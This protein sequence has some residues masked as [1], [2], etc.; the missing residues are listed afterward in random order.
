MPTKTKSKV[1]AKIKVAN[2]KPRPN[3][4][5]QS[6]SDRKQ[7]RDIKGTDSSS[8]RN[9]KELDVVWP[10]SYCNSGEPHYFIA[11]SSFDT[12]LQLFCCSKCQKYKLLPASLSDAKTFKSLCIQHG[13][14][15]GYKKFLAT[16]AGAVSLVK[17]LQQI[18][19][20]IADS[21]KR[22]EL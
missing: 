3:R 19:G 22:Y 8:R 5:R 10:S 7:D 4:H 20:I 11:L 6:N 14:D 1:G 13:I 2:D 17:A 15:L 21:N 9:T 16:H 12:G 18:S